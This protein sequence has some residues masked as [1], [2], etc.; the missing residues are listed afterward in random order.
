MPPDCRHTDVGQTV[1]MGEVGNSDG[2]RYQVHYLPCV[3]VDK[4]SLALNIYCFVR[5]YIHQC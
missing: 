3:A 5:V 4:Y 2:G 1:Q